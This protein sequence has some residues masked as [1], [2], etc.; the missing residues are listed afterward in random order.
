[1]FENHENDDVSCFAKTLFQRLLDIRMSSE[2]LRLTPQDVGN[3]RPALKAT[4]HNQSLHK[5]LE[6]RP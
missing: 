2:L 5:H 4:F 6:R 1:M 3:K